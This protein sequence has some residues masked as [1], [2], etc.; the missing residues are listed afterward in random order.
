MKLAIGTAQ[1]GMDYGINNPAGRVSLPQVRGILETGAEAGI[2]ML[3]TAIAYGHSEERL[4]E[5]GVDCWKVVTKIPPVPED[6]ADTREWILR[7][8]RG[9]M[10]RLHVANLYGLLLHRPEDLLG[11][12]GSRIRDVLLELKGEGLVLKVGVSIYEPAILQPLLD[13][14]RLDLVQGPFNVLDRRLSS[15]GWLEE[16]KLAGVEV[17]ARSVFLQGLLLMPIA[18]QSR[19]FPCWAPLW[20]HW[21]AWLAATDQTA[22]AACLG[23]VAAFPGIDRVVVGVDSTAQ[24]RELVKLSACVRP[25]IPPGIESYDPDLINPSHWAGR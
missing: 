4:G 12:H 17:H 15:S 14:A 7:Q 25:G 2:D 5:I 19:R 21:S 9:S 13:V 16:L 1:L 23:F 3:D 6:V 20:R 22:S 24:L 18:E 8:V 11:R 10:E